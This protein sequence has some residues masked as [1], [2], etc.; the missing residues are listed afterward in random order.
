MNEFSHSTDEPVKTVD[1]G[2]MAEFMAA[3]SERFAAIRTMTLKPVPPENPVRITTHPFLLEALIFQCLNFAMDAAKGGKTISLIPENTDTGAR[4]RF[5]G[6]EGLAELQRNFPGEKEEPLLAFLKAEIAT[7][8]NA[9]E[10]I[11]KIEN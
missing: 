3:I 6:L 1:M 9:G 8:T 5:A 4:L 7:D 2:E 11:L 10:L